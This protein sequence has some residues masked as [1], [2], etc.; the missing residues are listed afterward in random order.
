MILLLA[1]KIRDGISSA[2]SDRYVKSDEYKKISY[3][4]AN[5]FYGYSRS[6]PLPY[7][8]IKNEKLFA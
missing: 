5:I 6:Q 4:D 2:M 3:M 7:Y 8:E 1:N